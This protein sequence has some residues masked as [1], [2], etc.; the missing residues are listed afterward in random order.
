MSSVVRFVGRRIFLSQTRK[1]RWVSRIVTVV[2]VTRFV[3]RASTRV[4]R[5]VLAK[6]ESMEI[7]ITKN[8]QRT[9]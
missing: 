4:R 3:T 2:G 9:S 8:G 7:R 5:V 1:V 6:D